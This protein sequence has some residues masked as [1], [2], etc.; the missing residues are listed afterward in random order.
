MRGTLLAAAVLEDIAILTDGKAI[1][2]NLGVKIENV[3]LDDLG[4]AKRIS[5]DK[6]NTTIIEGAGKSPDIGGG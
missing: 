1:S 5:I 4:R 6:D 3:K 2:E